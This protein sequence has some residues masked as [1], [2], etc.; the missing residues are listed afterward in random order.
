[1]FARLR[2]DRWQVKYFCYPQRV[3]AQL[4]HTDALLNKY[5]S[6]L[7]KSEEFARLILDEQWQ[8]AEAVSLNN[9]SMWKL[10]TY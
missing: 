5:V 3:A 8:G 1:M 6:I 2:P 9:H 7:S 4:E 10:S